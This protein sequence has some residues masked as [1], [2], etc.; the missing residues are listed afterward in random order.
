MPKSKFVDFKA[1]K[2]AITMEQV[3]EHYG[4]LEGFKRSGD[5][6]SGPCPIHKGENSTQF[7]V[8]VSKNCWNCF[9]ECKRG[10]NILDFVSLMEDV[11][12]REAAIRIADWFNLTF[13]KPAKKDAPKGAPKETP[14]KA[15]SP[16]SPPKE[17]SEAPEMGPNKPLGF[18]LRNLDPAHPYLAERGLSGE[19]IAEFGLG[20][21][22][23][24]SMNGRIVI[25]IHNVD[26][27][28]VAYAGR[29]PGDPPEDTPKYKLPAGFRKSEE[30]FNLHRALQADPAMPLVIVEGFF[31][32]LHLWQKG[33]SRVVALMG[34]QLSQPQEELLAKHL[35]PADR[36][37]VMLD[38]DNAG[39]AGREQVLQRL[40][41]RA[42]V[43]VFRFPQ[44][45]QQPTDLSAEDLQFLADGAE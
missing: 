1:V 26:G 24:G 19:T 32:C 9:G 3:L 42:F 40:A 2:E 28:L 14:G 16:Q 36:I 37:I 13:D 41:T 11:S 30:L 21:C 35:E 5:S 39:R 15:E 34:S 7:R 31:H 20:C 17:T 22:N 4:L 44:E 8:S 45:G 43:R 12:V 27:K 29:W 33:F 25:P 38:E 18:E 23:K 6:L 10:G